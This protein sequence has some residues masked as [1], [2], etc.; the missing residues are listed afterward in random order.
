MQHPLPIPNISITMTRVY[1]FPQWSLYIFTFVLLLGHV[2]SQNRTFS[3]VSINPDVPAL[4]GKDIVRESSEAFVGI[5]IGL[6]PSVPLI[7]FIYNQNLYINCSTSP[8]GACIGYYLK[9]LGGASTG[10]D[11]EFS[12][13][14]EIPTANIGSFA[15]TFAVQSINGSDLLVNS[16]D[17]GTGLNG[18][19]L[20]QLCECIG[21]PPGSCYA[22]CILL[23]LSLRTFPRRHSANS[24]K[25]TPSVTNTPCIYGTEFKVIYTDT[26]PCSE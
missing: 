2:Y 19:P 11:F 18:T 20:Y 26:Y 24:V 1:V 7:T 17:E 10:W 25:L 23:S 8:T 16:V 4:D 15:G 12:N 5:G 6:D 14:E 21:S 22:V 13:N 3:L 9:N